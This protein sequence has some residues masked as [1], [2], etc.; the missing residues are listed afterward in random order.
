MAS[1]YGDDGDGVQGGVDGVQ[2]MV[3]YEKVAHYLP[4][5]WTIQHM[6]LTSE[7]GEEVMEE[8]CQLEIDFFRSQEEREVAMDLMNKEIESGLSWPFEQQF[9]DFSSFSRYFLSHSAFVVRVKNY[10]EKSEG[11][12][13]LVP[14]GL[15]GCFYVKPNFPGRCSHV[16]N[17]GFIVR[18]EV[19]GNG[20]GQRMGRAF[21]PL[22]RDLGYLA[23]FFN[24]VF[25]SNGVSDRMWQKLGYTMVGVVPKVARL[26]GMQELVDAKQYYYDLTTVTDYQQ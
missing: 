1:C 7:G 16:C 18:K 8:N 14:H 3:G 26:K 9:Q 19:R 6:R 10:K 17:G 20:V 11:F 22:A 24:L 15:A 12:Q 23:S 25:V 13:S 2:G 5:S 21:L 4:I